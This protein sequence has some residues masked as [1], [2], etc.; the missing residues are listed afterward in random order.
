MGWGSCRAQQA[1]VEVCPPRTGKKKGGGGIVVRRTRCRRRAGN[2]AGAGALETPTPT[3][4]SKTL[5]S[6]SD[7]N[8]SS[9]MITKQRSGA[10]REHE[11]GLAD[12]VYERADVG[13]AVNV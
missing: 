2:H 1:L 4:T 8:S 6:T 3:P 5:M 12:H 11:Q 9:N 7:A 13:Q 10:E